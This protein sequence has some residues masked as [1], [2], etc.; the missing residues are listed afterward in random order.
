MVKMDSLQT[1]ITHSN[2]KVISMQEFLLNNYSFTIHFVEILAAVTGMFFYKKYKDT[3]ARYF[4]WFLV[5][6][7]ILELIGT[8]PTFV[9]NYEFLSSVRGYL[10]GT[11][12]ERNYWWY[13]IFWR[14]GS[15]LFYAFYFSKII[16]SKKTIKVIQISAVIFGFCAPLYISMH[17]EAFFVSSFSF[18]NIFGVSVIL[19]SI[20][21]YFVEVLQSDEILVFYKSLDFYIGSV[22]FIYFLIK[23]P[24]VFYDI[25]FS[26]SD[27]A[28]VMLKATINLVCIVFMYLTFTFALIW[29]KPQNV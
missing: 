17:W 1:P 23:T 3:V 2:N 8:Y 15:V 29:C 22:L 13:T 28:F 26:R 25:Y 4:I 27:M 7:V 11:K 10:E 12:F 14:I 19:L 21:L 6:V 18:V 5:Y 24:L 20:V 16:K 9:K